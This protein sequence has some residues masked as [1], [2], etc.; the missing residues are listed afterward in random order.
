MRQPGRIERHGVVAG[1]RSLWQRLVQGWARRAKVPEIPDELWAD[2]LRSHDFLAAL[3]APDQRRLRALSA[4]FLRQKQFHGAQ[5]LPV[6]DAMAVSIAAQ[7]CRPLIRLD[8]SASTVKL[9][10]WY[11]DFVGIVV[12]PD[13][14]LAQRE[15]V[16]DI[17][18]V[19]R[20]GE[21]LAGEAMDGGP[22]MLNWHD[23]QNANHDAA[24]GVNLVIHEFAHK[25]DMRGGTADGCP[26]LPTGFAGTRS[27]R[28]AH[29]YWF[30]A[31]NAGY[32]RHREAVAMAERF[33]A[34]QPWLDSY[35]AE[36]P[37]EFF[38]VACE[39]YFVQ[40]ER[41]RQHFAQVAACFD[42]FFE[43]PSTHA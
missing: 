2:T 30:D 37:V 25:L 33:G 5:G 12:H 31:L 29:Q 24:L 28:Q 19:H 4:E 35:A 42:A 36:S 18:V 10:R 41:F 34:D 13:E 16:D 11:D 14:V 7:A 39:A 43:P 27:A 23:I 40:P 17:G 38:A 21:R 8:A 3:P 20:Y 1:V 9:L 32:Q 6:S 22:V 26:P 15:S